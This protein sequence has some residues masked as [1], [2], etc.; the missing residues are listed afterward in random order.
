MAVYVDN[1]RARYGRMIMCHMIADTDQ[2]LRD[3]AAR[4]GVQ[5]HWHQGEHFDVCL[6][7]RA[8]AVAAGAQEIAFRQCAAMR[9]RRRYTGALGG[10]RSGAGLVAGVRTRRRKRRPGCCS[11]AD[12]LRGPAASQSLFTLRQPPRHRLRHCR[13]H[14]RANQ[15]AIPRCNPQ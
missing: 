8:L 15:G 5:L 1:M 11:V 10:A 4:I 6:E 14:S 3:M 13:T 9:I 7:K 2:E 12:W